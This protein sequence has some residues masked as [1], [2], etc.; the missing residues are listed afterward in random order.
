M[1]RST[2]PAPITVGTPTYM[3]LTPYWP[4]RCAA[5]GQNALLVL[6]VGLGHLDCRGCRSVVGRTGLQEADDF[7]TAVTGA[8][9][10]LLE[11]FLGDPT[12][13]DEVG[14][15]NAGNGGVASKRHHRVAVAAEN[16]SSD[17]LNGNVEFLGEEEAKARAI[18]NARHADDL[19]GRKAGKLLQRPNHGVER[20]G[21]ADRRKRSGH[22]S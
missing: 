14:E 12:H 4:E 21:D 17:V 9:D 10:D 13:G 5:T 22:I 19:V 3:S 2:P 16:E 18:E 11:P 7:G 20:I 15:R 6:E 8:L 1:T